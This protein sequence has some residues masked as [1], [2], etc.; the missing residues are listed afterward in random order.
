VFN[1]E[2][3]VMPMFV[4]S[5]YSMAVVV[6]IN[7]LAH[8]IT[9]GVWAVG[10]WLSLGIGAL[11]ANAGMALLMLVLYFLLAA[12]I[13]YVLPLAFLQDEPLI[14]AMRLSLRMSL[15]HAFALLVISGLLLGL[16]FLG[17]LSALWSVW[18]SYLVWLVAGMFILP[19]AVTSAYCSYRT[20]FPRKEPHTA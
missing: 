6:L 17:V 12:S 18:V 3:R 10:S 4:V 5:I 16:Y 14:P 19:L 20:V 1:S 13:V 7:I 11:L 2:E 8:L 15:R 9:N